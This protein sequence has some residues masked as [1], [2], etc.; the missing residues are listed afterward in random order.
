MIYTPC[1]EVFETSQLLLQLTNLPEDISLNVTYS[2]SLNSNAQEMSDTDYSANDHVFNVEMDKSSGS[3]TEISSSSS[4]NSSISKSGLSLLDLLGKPHLASDVEPFIYSSHHCS[5]LKTFKPQVTR[6]VAAI[7]EYNHACSHYVFI[8]GK[9]TACL[10]QST[11]NHS[12]L[13]ETGSK[14]SSLIA[15]EVAWDPLR[16]HTKS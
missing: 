5:P 3:V 12:F 6:A 14:R 4:V 2:K 7:L 8:Q 1:G 9:T 16:S 10:K 11:E 13:L 15:P